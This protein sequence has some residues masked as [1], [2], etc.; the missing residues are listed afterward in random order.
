MAS[1]R[2]RASRKRRLPKE[3]PVVEQAV[4]ITPEI[5]VVGDVAV[6]VASLDEFKPIPRSLSLSDTQR[7]I[8]KLSAVPLFAAYIASFSMWTDKVGNVVTGLGLGGWGDLLF[9]IRAAV[10]FAEQG[11]WPK[12][13][14][15]IAGNPVGYAFVSD[16]ISGLL[17]RAGFSIAASF[18]IPTIILVAIFIGLLEWVVLRITRSP[19]AAILSAILFICFGGLSGWSI[20]SE[21]S[22]DSW[23]K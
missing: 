3:L 1:S 6:G 21:L 15:F 14:F 13:S 23:T 18:S 12:E 11:G 20:L 19:R 4:P 22:P 17:W 7:L 9:H 5:A 10:F 8:L 2:K 16:F